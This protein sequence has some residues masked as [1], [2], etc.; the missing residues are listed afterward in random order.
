MVGVADDSADH[1]RIELPK[2]L[3]VE[4]ASECR[5]FEKLLGELDI[6]KSIQVI[7]YHGIH[8][9]KGF[10]HT[11]PVRP[12]YSLV[13]SL[14]VTRDADESSV[15]AFQSVC[16]LLR[17]A[18]FDAP[19]R[20]NDQTLGNPRVSVFILP[21]GENAG[22][23]ETLCLSAVQD[24]PA[25]PCVEQYFQCL[26]DTATLPTRNPDK[27]RAHVFLASRDRPELRVGE[28]A[29]A[30]HWRLDSPVYSPL[31]RFLQAL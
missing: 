6:S 19:D 13:D 10:L 5:F 26:A 3:L 18:G 25:I 20:T 8:R 23:L 14:G 4:G 17:N 12:E 24:D 11:L 30:G 22:M 21:D 15:S 7:N 1:V 27:A 2:V 29:E 31:K 9:L 28:A 16:S